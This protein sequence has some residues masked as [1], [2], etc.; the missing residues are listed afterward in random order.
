MANPPKPDVEVSKIIAMQR[1]AYD[2]VVNGRE[3]FADYGKAGSGKTLIAQ[4]LCDKFE[5]RVQAAAGT[6]KAASNFNGPTIHGCFMWSAKGTVDARSM[7]PVKKQTLQNF[8]ENTELFI[9]DEISACGADLLYLIDKTM[10]ELF[11]KLI[12]VTGKR[13]GEPFG[14]KTVVFL[15]DSA[16]LRPINAAAIYDS[17]VISK[18]KPYKSNSKKTYMINAQKGQKMYR[19]YLVPKCIWLQKG[20]R[21]AG[22]LLKIMY[23]LRNGKQTDEDLDKLL[24]QRQRYPELITARGIHYSNDSAAFYNYCQLWDD[25]KLLNMYFHTC[26]ALYHMDDNNE[27]VV[28]TLSGVSASY[29]TDI[30]ALILGCEVRLITNLDTS[31]GLVTNTT[32]HMVEIIYDN[33][34]APALSRG[35]HPPPYCIVVAFPSFR[36]FPCS[37]STHERYYPFSNHQLVRS[38]PSI[39]DGLR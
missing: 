10:R 18:A 6:G 29:A 36:G 9:F 19:Q 21:N 15:G 30:L 39:E 27:Y 20:K 33:S 12:P 34:D 2:L 16:Q 14:G 17:S 38:C 25:C 35:E 1:H 4:H 22:L 8:Y 37:S 24:F 13:I 23:N 5:G 28:R 31:A 7:S 26:R 11:C 32:G 3:N